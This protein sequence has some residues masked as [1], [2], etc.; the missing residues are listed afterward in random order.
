[1]TKQ[2][3]E[4]IVVSPAIWLGGNLQVQPGDLSRFAPY[5]NGVY[6]YQGNSL[7]PIKSDPPQEP[8]GGLIYFDNHVNREDFLGFLRMMKIREDRKDYAA[9]IQEACNPFNERYFKQMRLISKFGLRFMF[10]AIDE[11]EYS[12]FK[13]QELTIGEALWEFMESERGRFGTSFWDPRIERKMGG[14]GNYA[15]EQL[16]F[17]FMLENGYHQVYRIWSR[18][19]L[20]TK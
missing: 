7:E 17:G 3:L 13:E 16:G 2:G 9:F 15:R 12:S 5:G 1:M 19:W 4:K 18:A 6:G 20:V 10:E 14:D 11:R 8:A